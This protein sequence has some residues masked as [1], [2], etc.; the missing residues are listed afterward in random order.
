MHK[1]SKNTVS[2]RPHLRILQRIRS[3][4]TVQMDPDLQGPIYLQGYAGIRTSFKEK[5][6]EVQLHRPQQVNKA[7]FH[8]HMPDCGAIKGLTSWTTLLTLLHGSTK[9]VRCGHVTW[10]PVLSTNFYHGS[11]F[12]PCQFEHSSMGCFFAVN[13]S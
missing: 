6:E 3:L 13:S 11:V 5:E 10:Q 7:T 12:L 9:A 2:K 1:A 8:V 4:K